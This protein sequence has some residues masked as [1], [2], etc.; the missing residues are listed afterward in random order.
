MLRASAAWQSASIQR[1]P[2]PAVWWQR[3][4]H[5][6]ASADWTWRNTDMGL[7]KVIPLEVKCVHAN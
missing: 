3:A 1:K 2:V 7:V 5:L 6:L 4:R